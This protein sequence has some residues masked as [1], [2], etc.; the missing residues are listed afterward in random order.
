MK[1]KVVEHEWSRTEDDGWVES[2]TLVAAKRPGST[3]T[4]PDEAPAPLEGLYWDIDGSDLRIL[5]ANEAREY[6][7]LFEKIIEAEESGD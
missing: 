5:D 7:K 6:I 4:S 2:G 3:Y 1:T